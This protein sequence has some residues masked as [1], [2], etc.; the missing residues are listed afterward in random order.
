MVKK[1][2]SR[3][4]ESWRPSHYAILSSLFA[5]LRVPARLVFSFC[6]SRSFFKLRLSWMDEDRSDVPSDD[7][8][9]A[10]EF[11]RSKLQS[12]AILDIVESQEGYPSF[13]REKVAVL[14]VADP[15]NPLR[16]A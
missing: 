12:A 3:L 1:T 11:Y 9:D 16:C 13:S 5:L 10:L 4:S 7:A 6:F 14:V 2:K 8:Q 15:R